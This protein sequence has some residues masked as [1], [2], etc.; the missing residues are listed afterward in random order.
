MDTSTEEREWPEPGESSSS[1]WNPSG[2]FRPLRRIVT[3]LTGGCII[4]IVLATLVLS[5]LGGPAILLG[6][7]AV[8]I[9][10][11]P[12]LFFA[13]AVLWFIDTILAYLKR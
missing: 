11:L 9:S 12:L 2:P 13:W 6:L 8:L 4:A 5:I 10:T 7:D 3:W 1:F